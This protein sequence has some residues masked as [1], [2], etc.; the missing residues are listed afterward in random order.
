MF[1]AHIFCSR[2]VFEVRR[3]RDSRSAAQYLIHKINA[4]KRTAWK[5]NSRHIQ[6]RLASKYQYT[7]LRNSRNIK[8]NYTSK[9]GKKAEQ[10]NRLFF[11]QSTCFAFISVISVRLFLATLIFDRVFRKREIFRPKFMERS[12]KA[13]NLS[14]W[15]SYEIASLVF[16]ENDSTELGCLIKTIH[17][18]FRVHVSWN[19]FFL[20]LFS[21]QRNLLLPPLYESFCAFYNFFWTRIIDERWKFAERLKSYATNCVSFGVGKFAVVRVLQQRFFCVFCWLCLSSLRWI[22]CKYDNAASRDFFYWL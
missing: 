12:M 22:E 5:V 1:P 6:M 8:H 9:L 16:K 10:S 19:F 11:S 18:K 7:F 4:V 17:R 21:F 15:N 20:R 13:H 14:S 3:T 2:N